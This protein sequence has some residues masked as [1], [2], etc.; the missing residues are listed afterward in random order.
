MRTTSA[1][2]EETDPASISRSKAV[3]AASAMPKAVGQR[4]F[5]K[6]AQRLRPDG[7]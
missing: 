6:S 4:C 1:E 2:S 3:R 7:R 5:R